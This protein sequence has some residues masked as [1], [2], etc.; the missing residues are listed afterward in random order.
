MHLCV[1][2]KIKAAELIIFFIAVLILLNCR[3]GT[4]KNESENNKTIDRL[5]YLYSIE[6]QIK[7]DS[8]KLML[9]TQWQTFKSES[10]EKI[11]TNN[12]RIIA[13]KLK[14][15]IGNKRTDSIDEIKINELI[16]GNDLLKFGI[17]NYR[18]Y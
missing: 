6:Y 1:V 8:Q 10:F 16:R 17:D 18:L 15:G 3:T 11:N 9:T 7:K 12:E 5:K 2:K 4:H 14:M 13:L